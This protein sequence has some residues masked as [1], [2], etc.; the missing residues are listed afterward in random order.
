[1]S[2]ASSAVRENEK[3]K[4]FIKWVD[5][6]GESFT[7]Q[8]ETHDISETGISFYLKNPVWVDTHLTIK[9][10]SSNLFGHLHT[11]TAKVV[12]VHVDYSGEQ[13]VAARF[14]E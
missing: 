13:I 2:K 12:R 8:T 10:S 3:S 5:A 11:I 1:M 4:L 6:N 14:D 9:I 7:E